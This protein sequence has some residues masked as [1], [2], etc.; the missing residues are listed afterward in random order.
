MYF[1]LARK[2]FAEPLPPDE[3]ELIAIIPTSLSKAKELLYQGSIIDAKTALGI[4]LADN[5][6]KNCPLFEK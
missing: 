4:T 3:D 2:L 5:Y 1:F 6:L